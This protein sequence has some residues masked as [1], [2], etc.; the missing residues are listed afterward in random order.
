MC[1]RI[2]FERQRMLV[3][4]EMARKLEVDTGTLSRWERGLRLPSMKYS[5]SI[6]VLEDIS[7]SK[8]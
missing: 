2:N 8:S 3:G 7:E 6:D 5:A 1:G 4:R